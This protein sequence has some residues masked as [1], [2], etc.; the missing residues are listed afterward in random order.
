MAL[1]ELPQVALQ[2][3]EK[4]ALKSAGFPLMSGLASPSESE[5]KNKTI[6]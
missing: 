5:G 6:F 4:I 2:H 1:Q 3:Q